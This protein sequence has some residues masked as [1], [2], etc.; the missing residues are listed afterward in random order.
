[1]KKQNIPFDILVH[2]Q[3][4][5]VRA[6]G[7]K[8]FTLQGEKFIIHRRYYDKEFS[9]KYW[10]VSHFNTGVGTGIVEQTQ[11]KAYYSFKVKVKDYKAN[12]KSL[13][14][15]KVKINPDNLYP[16]LKCQKFFLTTNALYSACGNSTKQPH[17]RKR[18]CKQFKERSCQK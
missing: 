7:I 13:I 9:K 16:C 11:E 1:M 10:A 17:L 12:L 15:N 14:R 5:R 3:K 18:I 2:D 8:T 6:T 4:Y